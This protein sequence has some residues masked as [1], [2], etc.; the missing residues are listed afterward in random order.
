MTII[1]DKTNYLLVL[2][3]SPTIEDETVYPELEK[4]VNDYLSKGSR[5]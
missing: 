4:A 3:I 5:N 2:Q 1:A